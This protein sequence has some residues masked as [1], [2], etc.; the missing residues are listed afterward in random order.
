MRKYK[1]KVPT[2]D[3]IPT[4]PTIA[5]MPTMRGRRGRRGTHL[6]GGVLYKKSV[7]QGLQRLLAWKWG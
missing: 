5:T 1:D 4:I 6:R 7:V 3:T 2:I